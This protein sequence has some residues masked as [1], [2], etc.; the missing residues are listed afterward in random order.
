[1][2]LLFLVLGFLLGEIGFIIGTILCE[3]IFSVYES[4]GGG[5][6][7]S[8]SDIAEIREKLEKEASS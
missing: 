2:N 7:I 8:S 1:M 5:G 4:S 6:M 3:L